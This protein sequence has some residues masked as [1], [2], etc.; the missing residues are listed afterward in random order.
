MTALVKSS[1]RQEYGGSPKHREADA[2]VVPV[3]RNRS[4]ARDSLKRC[5]QRRPFPLLDRFCDLIC[6]NRKMLE[7]VFSILLIDF[8]ACL[9]SFAQSRD[10]A[11]NL[12]VAAIVKPPNGVR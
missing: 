6:N 10:G 11:G 8:A 5:Q 4:Y 12:F 9:N 3:S 1:T 2:I 7:D